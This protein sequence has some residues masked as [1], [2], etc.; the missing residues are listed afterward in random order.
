MH[1]EQSITS[2]LA[3]PSFG[4]FLS[5]AILEVVAEKTRQEQATVVAMDVITSYSLI[6]PES[7]S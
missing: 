3:F 5:C 2:Y 7:I 6:K 4:L 1:N